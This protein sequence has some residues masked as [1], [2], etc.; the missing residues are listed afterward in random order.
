ML[1]ALLFNGGRSIKTLK[2]L[3]TRRSAI[4]DCTVHHML[5]V[6]SSYCGSVPLHPNFTGTG[7]SPTKML[8]PFNRYLSSWSHWSKLLPKNYKFG[9]VN[10]ILGK[11]GVTHKLG[12]WLVGKSMV[13]LLFILIAH[14]SLS[15]TVPD[16]GVMRQNVYTL[17]VFAGSWLLCTE[18]LPGQDR[19]PS[20]TL[21]IR[22]LVKT[23]DYLTVKSTSLCISS[24][25]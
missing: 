9:Y 5:N 25:W 17:A 23:L 10:P 4:I 11:L 12:W 16:S 8:I 18:I 22:K 7:S 6:H 3:N 1:Q 19:P 20:T 2:T 14:F 24:F 15:I 13:D 21:G